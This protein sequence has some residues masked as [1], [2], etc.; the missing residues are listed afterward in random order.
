MTRPESCNPLIGTTSVFVG[1]SEIPS[2]PRGEL[3]SVQV[4]PL[5]VCSH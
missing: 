4:N 3:G 5:S 1:T 2:D